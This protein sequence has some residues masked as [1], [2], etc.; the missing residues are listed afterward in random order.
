MDGNTPTQQDWKH[1]TG[2]HFAL[3]PPF[4]ANGCYWHTSWM[5]VCNRWASITFKFHQ[6]CGDGVGGCFSFKEYHASHNSL[7]T[8]GQSFAD[9]SV[10]RENHSGIFTQPQVGI[11]SARLT[12]RGD[13]IQNKGRPALFIYCVVKTFFPSHISS[14]VQPK[15]ILLQYKSIVF[16]WTYKV[17][18]EEKKVFIGSEISKCRELWAPKM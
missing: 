11:E 4:S 12:R 9:P 13:K 14:Y 3:M 2:N 10:G 7:G 18:H 1:L 6:E 8:V 5:L 15:T 17:K 16:G